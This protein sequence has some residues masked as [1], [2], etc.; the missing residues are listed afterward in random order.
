MRDRGTVSAML[1]VQ[2]ALVF[3][4][5]LALADAASVLK[6]HARSRSAADAS[7]LAAAAEQWRFSGGGG[8]PT[9]EA[10]TYAE[11]NGASLESCDCPARGSRAVVEVSVR[12]R[13]RMLGSAPLNVRASAVAVV[14]PAPVFGPPDG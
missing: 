10:R 8:D 12:T 2:L 1:L 13:I 6:A 14:D 3:L 9:D 4:F 5:C 7:A 11:R